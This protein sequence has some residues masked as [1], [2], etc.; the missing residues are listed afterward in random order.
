MWGKN[1]PPT[2]RTLGVGFS[3]F[4]EHP[5]EVVGCQ[6]GGAGSFH[7]TQREV[8]GGTKIQEFEFVV[9]YWNFVATY[10]SFGALYLN[11][12]IIYLN[13]GA[14]YLN[15]GAKIENRVFGKVVGT[16]FGAGLVYFVFCL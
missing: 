14:I 5:W 3:I 15:F 4:Y 8:F 2:P 6:I 16:G 13:F 1:I 12:V 9:K 7:R 11:I 10:L